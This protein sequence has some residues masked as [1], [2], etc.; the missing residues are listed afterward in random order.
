MH[1]SEGA[2]FKAR[3]CVG[4]ATLNVFHCGE[5]RHWHLG[6]SS[7]AESDYDRQQKLDRLLG[8]GA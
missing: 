2:A 5:C 4:I 7:R 3:D 1:R 6:N 8:K